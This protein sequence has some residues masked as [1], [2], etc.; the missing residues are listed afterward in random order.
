MG[1][2]SNSVKGRHVTIEQQAGDDT[3]PFDRSN[4]TI[5]LQALRGERPSTLTELASATG[6][7]R[8]T[9]E[10]ALARLTE[11]GVVDELAAA[12]RGGKGRPARR[13]RFRP[14]AGI[15]L[16]IDIG[17]HH[18]I[19]M[20]ADLTGATVATVTV[21]VRASDPGDDRLAA[22]RAAIRDVLAEAGRTRTEVWAAAVGTSGIIHPDG[23]V[24]VAHVLPDWSGRNLVSQLRRSLSCPIQVENDANLAALA[25]HWR[26]VAVGVGDVV[27]VHASHRLGAGILIGGKVHRGFGGAAGEIGSLRMLHWDSAARHLA[28]MNHT[29][30]SDDLDNV[31]DRI[32]AAARDGDSEALATVEEFAHDLAAGI[33]AMASTIDPELVVV[34]GR[35]ARSADVVIPPVERRLAVLCIRPPRVAAS[36]LD[37]RAIALGAVRTALDYVER[38]IFLLPSR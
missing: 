22:T 19:A 18:I 10:D 5:T 20:L 35:V 6:L 29:V 30:S 34:G 24:L 12:A 15:V 33:A 21:P 25:E 38:E 3:S 37:D 1:T 7:S 31:A 8:P 11:L 9:V 13:Y 28:Q 23:R 2:V 14:E 36:T 17:E 16:G 4:V 27:Y 26:G 32:Y